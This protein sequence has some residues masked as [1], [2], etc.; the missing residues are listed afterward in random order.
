VVSRDPDLLDYAR[1]RSGYLVQALPWNTTYVLV[2]A[3]A[4]SAPSGPSD[5]QR[6]ALARDAVTGDARGALGPFGW[7]TD[8]AC[9]HEI[10]RATAAPRSIV[11]YPTGDAIARQIAERTVSL[12]AGGSR[13]A[14]LPAVLARNSTTGAR[15]ASVDPDSITRALTT[16]RAAAAIIPVARDWTT[17]CGTRANLPLPRGAIALVDARDHIIVRLGS[18][19]TVLIDASGALHAVKRG[20]R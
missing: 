9:L 8:P 2:T 20:A 19:A 14:W 16:G 13:E 17:P 11:A 18:G 4:D 1:R 15:I 7:L 5:A 3:G 6:E 10:P 12:A